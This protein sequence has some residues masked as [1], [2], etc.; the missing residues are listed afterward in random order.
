VT[1]T[2]KCIGCGAKSTHTFD[3]YPACDRCIL[4]CINVWPSGKITYPPLTPVQGAAAL[5]SIITR[6]P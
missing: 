6:T 4:A 3:G 5:A 1:T 2:L